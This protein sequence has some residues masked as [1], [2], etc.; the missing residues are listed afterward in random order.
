MMQAIGAIVAFLGI[1]AGMADSR[2][3]FAPFLIGAGM[4][5]FAVGSAYGI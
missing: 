1:F 4:L 2:N 3:E 5:I